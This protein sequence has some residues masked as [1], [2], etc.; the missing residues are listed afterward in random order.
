MPWYG[1]HL[2]LNKYIKENNCKKILE[3]GVY[4]GENALTMVEA[5]LQNFPPEEIE[6][7]GFD[8]FTYY[9]CNEIVRKLEKTECKFS[10]HKGNTIKT[11][12]EAI[13][14][15]PKMDLIFIDGGKSFSVAM[16]DWENCKLLMH[17]ETGV[18]V[19][20]ADFLGVRRMVENIPRDK[21]EVKI[22]RA[23]SEGTVALIKKL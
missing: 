7:Y 4:D 1:S 3:I 13:M 17:D 15:L 12:P 8:F 5:A 23:Q 10:L 11:L 19:H 22:F 9:S 6:Y 14:S 2:Y 20:N 21:Y 18:F 16:S